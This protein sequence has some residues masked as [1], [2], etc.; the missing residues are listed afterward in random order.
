MRW[1]GKET[2]SQFIDNYLAELGKIKISEPNIRR[3]PCGPAMDSE[4]TLA[5]VKG[6]RSSISPVRLA[7][8]FLNGSVFLGPPEPL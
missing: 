1:D 3:V 6:F 4:S 5:R 8:L 7:I 2:V